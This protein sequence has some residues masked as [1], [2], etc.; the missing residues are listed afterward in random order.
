MAPNRALY[1]SLPVGGPGLRPLRGFLRHIFAVAE[2][3]SRFL[4]RDRQNLIYSRNVMRNCTPRRFIKNYKSML[5]KIP[6]YDNIF[7][8][9]M[10]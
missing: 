3:A 7:Y 4:C 8:K 2:T 10:C 6:G 1:V 5:T 9:Q